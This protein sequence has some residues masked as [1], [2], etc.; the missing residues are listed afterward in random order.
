MSVLLDL[1]GTSIQVDLARRVALDLGEVVAQL[2]ASGT[3][4]AARGHVKALE[5]RQSA[6]VMFLELEKGEGGPR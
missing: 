4:A 3:L 6:L 1:F 5:C 2:D